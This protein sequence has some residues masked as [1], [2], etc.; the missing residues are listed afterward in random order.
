MM[1]SNSRHSP[2]VTFDLVHPVEVHAAYAL[3]RG[4][5]M[6]EDSSPFEL[7]QYRQ[8]NAPELFFGAFVSLPPPKVAG[9][10]SFTVPEARRRLIGFISATA[11]PALIAQ[12]FYKHSKSEYANVICL[13]SVCVDRAYSR[14]GIGI[15][16]LSNFI[17]R[18]QQ[19]ENGNGRDGAK[20]KGYEMMALLCGERHARFFEKAGFQ[21]HAI[22]YIQH[23]SRSEWIEMRRSIN[24]VPP[25]M[26]LDPSALSVP[27]SIFTDLPLDAEPVELAKAADEAPPAQEAEDLVQSDA[28]IVTDS[29]EGTSESTEVPGLQPQREPE[30]DLVNLLS[31]KHFSGGAAHD[32]ML[33]NIGPAKERPTGRPLWTVMGQAVSAKTPTEDPIVA[34]E[35]RIVDWR[36]DSNITRLLCPKEGCG[37][38]LVNKNSAFWAKK[39]IGPLANTTLHFSENGN[40]VTVESEGD[41]SWLTPVL[42][43]ETGPA[44]AN[45]PVRAFWLLP[46]PMS[47]DNVSFS[48]DV[49]WRYPS[50]PSTPTSPVSSPPSKAESFGLRRSSRMGSIGS[51]RRDS[52]SSTAS[53]L[54]PQTGETYSLGLTPDVD[55]T[56]KFIM[57]PDCDAGPLGFMLPSLSPSESNS[58]QP[59][60]SRQRCYVAAHRVRYED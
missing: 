47:F 32:L 17:H 34:L 20:P 21:R 39:E 38:V 15:S 12:S 11:A 59:D 25:K 42:R 6:V 57:C 35:A 23:G 52:K 24:D 41:L 19:V 45:G 51:S 56:V 9:P 58:P 53:D 7:L 2:T 10:L 54:D 18:V 44:R 49:Q 40:V 30:D 60:Y 37:C 55:Y 46:G 43:Q 28:S 16:M 4:R 8:K 29:A 48:R 5:R 14:R 3:E 26:Y 22:S 36:G 27:S 1:R 31:K 33:P 50:A 13:H